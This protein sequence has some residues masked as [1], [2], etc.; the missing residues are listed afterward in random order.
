MRRD[1]EDPLST[2]CSPY[3]TTSPAALFLRWSLAP[4]GPESR[5]NRQR[6]G[7]RGIAGRSRRERVGGAWAGSL[8]GRLVGNSGH[9]F[10]QRR[11]HHIA[12]RGAML[13]KAEETCNA[14][15]KLHSGLGGDHPRA[16][17]GPEGLAREHL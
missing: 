6:K 9:I 4:W 17:R 14:I 15:S 10:S 16:S 1:P 2:R 3:W 11:Y 5:S 7:V 8:A 12:S 13:G